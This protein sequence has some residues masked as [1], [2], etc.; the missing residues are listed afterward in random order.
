MPDKLKNERG[1]SLAEMLVA[2]LI[3]SLVTTAIAGAATTV[4]RVYEKVRLKA[5]AQTLMSTVV[6]SMCGELRNVSEEPKTDADR[7]YHYNVDSGQ[8]P[9]TAADGEFYVVTSDKLYSPERPD[10]FWIKNDDEKDIVTTK[11]KNSEDDLNPLVTTKTKSLDLRVRLEEFG[12][13]CLLYNG[14]GVFLFTVK[15]YT[16]NNVDAPLE[17]ETICVRSMLIP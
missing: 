1:A 10:G 6:S 16:G 11:D 5:D 14:D 12:D 9:N 3:L 15:V 8:K 7:R 4:Q 13:S 17:E 2:I